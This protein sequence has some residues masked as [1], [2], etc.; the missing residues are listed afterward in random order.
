MMSQDYLFERLKIYGESDFYPFH[1]PGHKRNPRFC[2]GLDLHNADIT[3]ID[4]FDN[5]HDARGILRDAQERAGRLYGGSKTWFLVNGSTVG[6]LCAIAACCQPGDSLLMGRNC[7][8]AVYNG[9]YLNHLNPIYIY[10]KV[11]GLYGVYEGMDP[12]KVR[13]AFDRNPAIRAL[14]VTSPTYDGV[15]SD[16]R[17]IAKIA[18]EYGAVLIVDEAH[19]AHFGFSS[20]FPGSALASQADIVI[21]SV[22]KTLPAPTQSALIHVQGERVDREKL[23]RLLTYYQSSS[24]S[25][26]LMAGIDRCMQLIEDEGDVLFSEYSGRLDGLRRGLGELD[27]IKLAEKEDFDS[28]C[29]DYDRSKLF[30]YTGASSLNGQKLYDRLR[31]QYHLQMEMAGRQYT[32]GMTSFCDTEEGFDRLMAALI[33]IDRQLEPNESSGFLTG[34]MPWEDLQIPPMNIREAL[35]HK[36]KS[37]L[38]KESA[39]KISREYIYLYPPGIPLVAP[40]ET[41]RQETINQVLEYKQAGLSLSGV[42]DHTLT[43][44][45]VLTNVR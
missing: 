18:H 10:P 12:Q 33:T 43:T 26:I 21:H 37:V 7:H 44:I 25:Y 34:Y 4:G 2:S 9:V 30:L 35:D 45:E 13:R 36:F 6:L 23:G 27:H 31:D 5:L 3:E 19:G 20:Y 28:N 1:M 29:K 32:L 16:T 42:K 38:L 40:G 15:V 22:H 24:P 8:K 39:G 11:H 14:V 17:A 41:I